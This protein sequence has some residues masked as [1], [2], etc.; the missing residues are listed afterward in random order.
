[1]R[2]I[3]WDFEMQTDHLIS[4]RKKQTNKNWPYSVVFLFWVKQ[5]EKLN[6]FL[7]IAKELKMPQNMRGLGGYQLL[8]AGLERSPKG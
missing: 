4:T 6:K 2:K 5:S 3:L 8:M 1:M 7:D